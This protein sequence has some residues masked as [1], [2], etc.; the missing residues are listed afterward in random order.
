[1]ALT[2][3][4][5]ATASLITLTEA[6]RQVRAEDFSDDD[7]Y[8]E[9]LIA[10]VSDTLVGPSGWLGRSVVETEWSYRL[11]RF[12]ASA[13][14]LPL[15][16]LIEVS[17][18]EY[19]D[20]SGAT[21]TISGYRTFGMGA[22]DAAGYIVPAYGSDWPQTRDEP[23]AVRIQ[24]KSGYATIPQAIKHGALLLLGHLYDN[25]A[26]VGEKIEVLPMGADALLM[27]YRFWPS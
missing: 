26:A 13:I 21:Q 20:V 4:T 3:V 18:V 6:K 25:R 14:S 2:L 16:P 9:G 22:V 15:P 23:E 24:F 27:P 12:T 1:M 7:P 19:V 10:T 5:A 8:L 17:E 11:N